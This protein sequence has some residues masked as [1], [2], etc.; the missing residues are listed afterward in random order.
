MRCAACA[1]ENRPGRKF[2]A[3]CGAPLHLACPSCGASNEPDESFC[4]ECGAAL[5]GGAPVAA[6]PTAPTSPSLRMP[7]P[8][9]HLA[10][11]I[12][13]TRR[14]LEGERKHITVL[15]ADVK[16]SM[17][18]SARFDPEQWFRIVEDFFEV[19]AEGVHRFEGTV[20]QFTGDGVMALFGAP[21][22][23]E[24]HAQRACLAAL[25]IRDSVRVFAESVRVRHGVQFSVRMGLNSDEV[26]IGRISD[27]LSMD[28]AALGHGVGLAQRMESL[29]EPGHICLS[30]N[31]ARLV[32]GYF[33]LRNLG[34]TEVKGVP[35]PMSLYDLEGAGTF[36]TRLDRSRARGLSQFVGRD[37][38][39]ASLEAALERSG[40][41]GQVVGLMAEAGTGKSR[42]CAEFLEGC[43]SRGVPVFEARGVPHGKSMPML[44]M[45]ELWRAY[46]RINE[47]DSPDTI[48]TKISGQ[49]TGMDESY[50]E[51]L[52]V[53]F[54]LFGVPDLEKPSPLADP[55]QRQKRLHS[56]VKRVLHD[57]AYRRAGP[58]VILLEDLHWFDGASN[59]FLETMVE[60]MP[61]TRDLLLVNFRPDYQAPWMHCSH[62]QHVTLQPLGPEAIRGL[63]RDYLGQGRSV[64]AL[65]GMIQERTKGNPF[66][67]EE[68]LQSL[69]ERGH[70]IGM[71][72]AYR[73]TAPLASLEVPESVRALLESRIDR[74]ADR[75]KH[76]LQ[77]ASV[78]G[79]QF[80]ES[81]LS[82]VL[83]LLR[84]ALANLSEPN[85]LSVANV[86]LDQALTALQAAEFL[87]EATV[88]PKVEY[89]FR[90]PL[91]QEVAQNSQL[92]ARRIRVH[93]AVARALEAAGG[94][95][96]EGAAEIALHWS[97]AE[98]L[99][100][101]ALWHRRAAAWAGLSDPREGLRHWRR[102]RDLASHVADEQARNGLTLQACKEILA[103]GWRGGVSA[104]EAESVF[105]QGRALAESLGDY[106]TV[107]VLLSSFGTARMSA[108]GSAT[109]YVRC[110][111]EAEPIVAAIAHPVVAATL[112]SFPMYAY[113]FAGYG[114]KVVEIADRVLAAVGSDNALGKDLTGFSP[115]VAAMQARTV[116]L[117]YLGRLNEADAQCREGLQLAESLGEI[118][119]L[120]WLDHD[121]TWLAYT[122]GDTSSVL[123][124]GR[125][126]LELAKKN[127]TDS[128]LVI[129]YFS[130]GNS[131]LMAGQ[132]AEAREALRESAEI[133]RERKAFAALLPQVLSVLAEAQLALGERGEAE[134]SAREAIE[135]AHAGG[136]DYYEAH[137]QLSLAQ[138]LLA[139][140]AGAPMGEVEKALNRAEELVEKTGGRALSPR[141]LE[142]R[143][144]LAEARGDA[145]AAEGWL[146]AALELYRALGATGHAA[147]LA[148]ARAK[149]TDPPKMG[150]SRP[151]ALHGV[152][153]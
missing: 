27:D 111:E 123:K 132:A 16:G 42:L 47:D 91:T 105:K 80:S 59:A 127:D 138:V 62:Y 100:N 107:A 140:G 109:D 72:G 129:G 121:A 64:A 150:G 143:G 106:L 98:E 116:G 113:L 103:L 119:L 89:S 4:G 31:T 117:M 57:P 51:D 20:H 60:A 90:H 102:V 40:V 55:E 88:W 137:A 66:F 96:D 35:E 99:G 23:H 141:I 115:R 49:L 94:N 56:V 146:W 101:A 77:T 151:P 1:H 133:A 108:A 124:H 30:E 86:A 9:A 104:E 44:P 76:V 114:A 28:F 92:R 147:R 69:I 149:E 54:D 25:H 142:L 139:A 153:G 5:A 75:E 74:L 52:P 48:R 18:L 7:A 37:R 65:P 71:R 110:A 34:R 41:T 135:R 152:G 46:Y 67:I 2:C 82:E 14:A 10:H 126:S 95:L 93:G 87:F 38:D 125:R 85:A 6:P 61:A 73:L 53:L 70:L 145:K 130:L 3:A 26:V 17:T 81:L 19:V 32:D 144:R 13:Q 24:D 68:V 29:A 112:G 11:K 120:G 118:E 36:R 78:I 15:F 33:Q 148:R 122:C 131:C 12:R 97:E 22:A 83:G 134:A 128:S 50:R 43:R 21:V 79:N 39:M 63:L 45:L 58:R 8:P 84:E 136:C